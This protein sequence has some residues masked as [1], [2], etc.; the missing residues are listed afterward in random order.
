VAARQL[1]E[2]KCSQCHKTTVVELA[3]P[4]SES[5]ARQLV[6]MM[7]DEGLEATE[8]ELA[9]L[10]RYLTDSFAKRSQ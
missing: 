3:P 5:E 9:Q 2:A 8:E 10:V 7:V 6:A 1:F 4:G